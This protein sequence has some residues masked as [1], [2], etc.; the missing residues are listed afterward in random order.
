MVFAGGYLIAWGLFGV[1]AT[2]ADWGLE[3]A[4]LIAPTTGRLVPVLGA[5]V[6]IA[7]GI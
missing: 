7:A 5:V 2:F 4:A 1:V 6:V 3:R